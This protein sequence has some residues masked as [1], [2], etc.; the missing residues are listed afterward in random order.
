MRHK[1]KVVAG[2]A[3]IAPKELSFPLQVGASF[4]KKIKVQNNKADAALAYKFQCNAP[5]RYAV[6]PASGVIPPL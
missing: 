2:V 1:E 4:T 6:T 5:S 3:S